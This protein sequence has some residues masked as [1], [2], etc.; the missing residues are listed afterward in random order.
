[1]RFIVSLTLLVFLSIS[2][3]AQFQ[4]ER[5]YPI[6]EK[7]IY[8]E[9][10]VPHGGGFFI[11]STVRDTAELDY[12]YMVNI[13][14][15][16]V[17]GGLRTS[18]D[19]IFGDSIRIA[20]V[21]GL[22]R[23][24]DGSLLFSVDLDTLSRNK[25]LVNFNPNGGQVNWV[26]RYGIEATDA[27]IA[28]LDYKTT[29]LSVNDST[30]LHMSSAFD[31][32]MTS[33][34]L[35]CVDNLGDQKWARAFNYTVD[36]EAFDE[37]WGS[38]T[39]NIYENTTGV[40][41]I[42]ADTNLVW[43]T[44]FDTLGLP[45]FSREYMFDGNDSRRLDVASVDQL[46][47]SSYMITGTVSDSLNN[48]RDHG[49]VMRVDTLGELIWAR[50]LDMLNSTNDV[51]IV[52]A[53]AKS[54][55]SII[56]GTRT[57]RLQNFAARMVEV[58]MNGNIIWE[59]TYKDLTENEFSRNGGGIAPIMSDGGIAYV[60]TGVTELDSDVGYLIRTDAIG[61]TRCHEVTSD[62]ELLPLSMSSDTLLWSF[63]TILG[64]DDIDVSITPFSNYD[65]PS[66]TLDNITYCPND[67][68]DT[69]LDATQALG[70]AYLWGSDANGETTPTLR[71]TEEGSYSVN[72]TIDTLHCFSLCDTASIQRSSLPQAS[73]FPNDLWCNSRSFELI[74]QNTNQTV[75]T[76]WSTGETSPS[77]IVTEF[78]TYSVTVV[79]NCGDS[80]NAQ[81]TF[82]P[83]DTTAADMIA[84]Q[85]GPDNDCFTPRAVLEVVDLNNIGSDMPGF[86]NIEWSTGETN[87]RVIRVT[88]TGTYTVTLTDDC[89]YDLEATVDIIPEDFGNMAD[90]QLTSSNEDYCSERTYT[91]VLDDSNIYDTFTWDIN[92]TTIID[93]DTVQVTELGTYNVIVTD[94]C[95]ESATVSITIDDSLTPAPDELVIESNL[96]FN[97]FVPQGELTV[98]SQSGDPISNIAW[99]TGANTQT[100]IINE[101]EEYSVSATDACDYLIN[102][103]IIT[104]PLNPAIPNPV[105]STSGIPDFCDDGTY[106]IDLENANLYT[107]IEWSTGDVNVEQLVVDSITTYGVSVF[108]QCSDIPMV[109][110]ILPDANEF[111]ACPCLEFPNLFAPA[112][113]TTAG[114]GPDSLNVVFA[115][116]NTCDES[117]ITAYELVIYNRWG[118]EV[119][120][121][122][123]LDTGW[124]GRRDNDRAPSEVYLYFARYITQGETFELEGHV[125]L[126]R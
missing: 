87:V 23:L 105:L 69:L 1:M 77:I 58:S 90:P 13:T 16:E 36:Q 11:L 88:Q 24:E 22:D 62:F 19:L 56:L 50:S 32:L 80:A 38:M 122:T 91:L 33:A 75:S 65:I 4:Y 84:I 15:L 9:E 18:Y 97:C 121:S 86:S 53:Y 94:R 107:I 115:P 61:A 72:V 123:E 51:I 64:Q 52:D 35:S 68:I 104:D 109:A 124:N 45:L 100:I 93:V 25:V 20:N 5:V 7:Q 3:H 30:N 117:L 47:D 27:S 41:Q 120:S 48:S 57:G 96:N 113:G 119:F 92:G 74:A 103:S 54:D 112:T 8:M 89:G 102:T 116:Y 39:T 82:S 29:S 73:I 98:S 26:N 2:V 114:G 85:V 99:S 71:V 55:T 111:P 17:K 81:Y 31:T 42:H 21:G 66:L 83:Q 6:P 76:A 28:A 44:Q 12:T 10:T 95:G 67:V 110:Q 70:S 49:F 60:T 101:Q 63:T 59:H 14:D 78:G 108:D 37:E 126:V 79:D 46:V 106:F 125:T 40:G 43:I 34:Y 118:Q